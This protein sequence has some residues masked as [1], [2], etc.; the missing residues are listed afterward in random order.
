MN[1]RIQELY[2]Q[3]C[4]KEWSYDFDTNKAELFALLIVR[5]CIERGN[6]LAD[7]YINNHTEKEQVFLLASIA[8]YSNEIKTHFGVEEPDDELEYCPKCNAPSSGTSCGLNDCGWIV[9]AEK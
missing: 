5:E 3:V 6:A 8:D 7:Y 2:T 4:G 9:G 1:E